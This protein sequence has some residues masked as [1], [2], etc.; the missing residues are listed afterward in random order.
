MTA[1]NDKHDHLGGLTGSRWTL[2]L[3]STWMEY[4]WSLAAPGT[5][6]WW[7]GFRVLASLIVMILLPGRLM[8]AE[9]PGW[10]CTGRS[11]T[12][13]PF[14]TMVAWT[15]TG[16]VVSFLMT[17]VSAAAQ[18]GSRASTSSA[19]TPFATGFPQRRRIMA[20]SS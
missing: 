10:T 17:S 2:L 9:S 12:T 16:T 19:S 1:G 7:T 14:T 4:S 20:P 6:C 11:R 3:L 13:L 5:T 15:M 18:R 8:L